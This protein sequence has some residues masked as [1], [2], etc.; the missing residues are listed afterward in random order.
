[1]CVHQVLPGMPHRSQ[2]STPYT[3][4]YTKRLFRLRTRTRTTD[5]LVY[6]FPYP[7]GSTY[8]W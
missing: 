5:L 6:I 7:R 2:S 1:M 4:R 8:V 3:R